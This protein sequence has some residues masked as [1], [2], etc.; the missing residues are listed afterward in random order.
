MVP[1]TEK[2]AAACVDYLEARPEVDLIVHGARD[3]QIPIDHG[4]KTYDAAKASPN[5]KLVLLQPED[6]GAEHC[7]IDNVPLARGIMADWIAEVLRA[8]R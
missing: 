3:R 5:R 2:P 4:Q 8:D 6:G 7:L 1:E